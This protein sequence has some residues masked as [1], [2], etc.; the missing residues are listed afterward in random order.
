[1]ISLK[2]EILLSILKL[3]DLAVLVLT[4]G[5]ATVP[6]LGV[7]H[8]ISVADFF[9]MRVKVGNLFIFLGLMI[10]WHALFSICGLY[11]S[12]RLSGRTSEIIDVVKATSLGTLCLLGVSLIFH[13]R[14]A[15]PP[16][17]GA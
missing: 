5:L 6:A 9:S 17:I 1:M 13:I 15:S 10:L 2:R 16:F 3:F 7:G 11:E 8:T 12:Y 14:M 4:F